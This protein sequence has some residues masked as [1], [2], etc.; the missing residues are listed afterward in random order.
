M[1]V[2]RITP[3]LAAEDFDAVREFYAGFVGLTE[4]DF[5]GDHVGFGAGPA[6]VVATRAGAALR[7]DLGI[8]VGTPDEVDRLHAA[9][10]ERGLEIVYGPVEEPWGVRRFFVRDPTGAVV[11]ILAHA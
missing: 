11:S 2:R 10:L 6:Q 3:Y 4:G 1:T 7:P 8:D 9:A 5:G